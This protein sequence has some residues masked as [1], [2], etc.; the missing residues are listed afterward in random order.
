MDRPPRLFDRFRR[1]AAEVT[2]SPDELRQLLGA[3]LSKAERAGR[4]SARFAEVRGE[5]N[6]FIGLLGAWA[7]GDYRAVSPKALVMVTAAVLYFLAPLDWVPDFILGLGL[8]DDVAVI[9]YVLGA[10]REEIA[11]F[12]RWRSEQAEGDAAH[13]DGDGVSSDGDSVSTAGSGASPDGESASPDGESASPDGEIALPDRESA[14]ANVDSASEP[15][16]GALPDGES[17]LL[18]GDED[19]SSDG[20][21]ASPDRNVDGQPPQREDEGR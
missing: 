7:R 10:V 4:L 17:A 14:S 16:N 11:A 12:E 19:A 6:A 15:G 20:G 2:R 1:R 18:G 9:G 5:L 3:A 8:L 21:S 13:S